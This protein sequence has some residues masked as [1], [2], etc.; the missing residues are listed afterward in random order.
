MLVKNHSGKSTNPNLGVM[1][2]GGAILL[3]TLIIVFS[4]DWSRVFQSTSTVSGSAAPVPTFSCDAEKLVSDEK[5]DRFESDG[6]FFGGGDLQSST[7]AFSGSYS[8]KLTK[9]NP[10][11]FTFDLQG[12]AQI[13]DRYEVSVWRFRSENL[14]VE[15][16]GRLVV[17]IIDSDDYLT[18]NMP[19]IRKDNGWERVSFRFVVPS[20]YKGGSLRVYAY[21]THHEPV[22]YDDLKIIKLP[23]TKSELARAAEDTVFRH[24]DLRIKEKGMNK[25][26]EKRAEAFRKWLLVSEED[27]WVKGKIGR[28][29]EKISVKLRLKGDLLDH[30]YGDKWS[31]RVKV[32]APQSWNRLMTFSLQNPATRNFLAEWCYHQ[33]MIQEDVLC[34]R[35]DFVRLFLNGKNMGPYAYEEHFEK[36]LLEFRARREGPIVKFAE[37]DMWQAR[38]RDLYNELDEK[39]SEHTLNQFEA[40]ETA[41]F[42][43]SKTLADSNLS[44]QFF[45]AQSLMK[46]YKYGEKPVEE[47]FDLD[48]LAKYYAITDIFKAYHG[49][50]WHNQRFYYNPVLG[51]L[52]PIG[53]DGFVF[54]SEMN[55]VGKPFM[56]FQLAE[57]EDDLELDLVNRLFFDQKFVER[58]I[59]FLWKYS[60]KQVLEDFFFDMEKAL[61]QREE[62]LQE[63]ARD[64]SFDKGFFLRS[65]RE[66]HSL[67]LP[68]NNALRTHATAKGNLMAANTHALPIRLLGYGSQATEQ[69]TTFEEGIWMPPHA[70][71]TPLD[72]QEIAVNQEASYL[73]YEIPGLDSVFSCQISRSPAPLPNTPPQAIFDKVSLESNEVYT[74]EGQ[75]VVFLPGTHSI[76]RD[77]VIPQGYQVIF[78]AGVSLDFVKGAAFISRSAV[79]MYG[80]AE[81]PIRIFSSDKTARGFTILQ[82]E[83]RSRMRY[84]TFDGFNT[85]IKGGWKLTGAVTFYE[86]DVDIRSCAFSNNVCEDALNLVRADFSMNESLVSYT[87]ADGFDADFCKGEVGRC[88]FIET[89]NDGMDFSGSVIT[90]KDCEVIS[91][92]DK[93]LSVGEEATVYVISLDI[94]DAVLGVASKDFSRLTIDKI[95]LKNCETGFSAYQKKPEYGPATIIVKSYETEDVKRLHLIERGSVLNLNGLVAET[96]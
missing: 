71:Q 12:D 60:E 53:F 88:K 34:P 8:C 27:D 14:K 58:Y 18:K 48:R 37:E 39:T 46:A 65:A 68:M 7:H 29:E 77:I 62:L 26:R 74:V 36:Q 87:F 28:G 35:Y 89:G 24:I 61:K 23:E 78:N 4:I 67:I 92:G 84:V 31:Y 11:G 52:E 64:Y 81:A 22:W 75:Q 57:K 38:R 95:N 66:V 44:Q 93:G 30:L 19:D 82:A 70:S 76:T 45:L 13:G 9:N 1:V 32:K 25:L 16:G 6:H 49:I 40:A 54:E 21:H 41:A 51:K 79:Q 56:L 85:L 5:A 96:I 73:F 15:L 94:S 17:H 86:S 83:Q 10:Y 80:E 91:P 63:E 43:Q 33:F 20:D 72:F 50:I 90:I 42:R 47:V 3:V 55:W 2:L 69:T 59:H